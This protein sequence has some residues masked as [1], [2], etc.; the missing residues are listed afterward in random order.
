VAK[1]ILVAWVL[2]IPVAALVS[3]VGY[4]VMHWVLDD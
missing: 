4:L 1:N 3:A 2:T